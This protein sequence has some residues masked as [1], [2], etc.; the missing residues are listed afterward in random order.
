MLGNRDLSPE[1]SWGLTGDVTLRSSDRVRLRAG[2]FAN[3]ISDLIDIDDPELGDPD[4]VSAPRTFSSSGVSVY[5]YKNI[6]HARTAGG[7]VSI[8][9]K[10]REWL[11]AE[12]GY[13]YLWTRNDSS[14]EPLPGR[15]SHSLTI[16]G[17]A[18]LPFGLQAYVRYKVVSSA[19][20]YVNEQPVE[21]S[22]ALLD[23]R[24]ALKLFPSL[25]AYIGGQNLGDARRDPQ[26]ANDLRPALGRTFYVG[27][28]G[29]VPGAE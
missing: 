28:R 6:A 17:T 10:V 12:C 8:R 9:A 3:W 11:S 1:T 27:L 20:G 16:P 19:H 26:N 22:F 29:D 2:A 14:G 21:G 18:E 23:A 7:D 25:E 24:V 13:A 4:L 15:P 5:R